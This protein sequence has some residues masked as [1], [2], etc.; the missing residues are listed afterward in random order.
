[1]AEQ[2]HNP[3]D[4][5]GS[6]ARSRIFILGFCAVLAGV[7][8]ISL[9]SNLGR[10]WE[11]WDTAGKTNASFTAAPRLE[12]LEILSRE[13]RHSVNVEVARTEN[14]RARGLMFRRTMPQDQGMLFDFQQDQMVSMWMKN[15]YIPLD[16]IFVFADG[17]IHRI[18]SR[19]EPESERVISSGVPVRAVLELNAGAAARLDLRPGDR[20]IHPIFR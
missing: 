12:R 14:E 3:G 18:E 11:N 5:I 1:M 8:A 7:V 16:M 2:K 10:M 9:T 20:L 13:R 15:T 17:R 4:K 6:L 19:T